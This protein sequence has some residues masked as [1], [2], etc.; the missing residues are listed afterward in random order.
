M[1]N[2]YHFPQ[3]Q[4]KRK[5]KYNKDQTRFAFSFL[6]G[7]R[8]L[9]KALSPRLELCLG[10]GENQVLQGVG[11]CFLHVFRRVEADLKGSSFLIKWFD[12]I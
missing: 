1:E 6:A 3:I 10:W 9:P 8:R 5:N 7:D 12:V 2:Q 4:S 11:D